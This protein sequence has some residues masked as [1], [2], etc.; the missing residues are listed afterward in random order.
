[1]K[2]P[3][4]TSTAEQSREGVKMT[5]QKE[6]IKEAI[7]ER[8]G[9]RCAEFCGGCACCEA[10]KAWDDLETAALETEG[11]AAII[12]AERAEVLSLRRQLEAVEAERD[13]IA[14]LAEKARREWE[15]WVIDQYEGTSSYI[16]AMAEV[17]EFFAALQKDTDNDV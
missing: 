1:M 3:Y 2:L 16:N 5:D 10:W 13:R 8:Y 4:S 11:F 14:K 12:A 7:T 9:D 17:R 6:L 15:G